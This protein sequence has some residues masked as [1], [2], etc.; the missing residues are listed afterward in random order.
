MNRTTG[1][2]EDFDP[3]V[4]GCYGR[5]PAVYAKVTSR[6]GGTQD[7]VFAYRIP[8]G[9]VCIAPANKKETVAVPT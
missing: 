2:L 3:P 5:V 8:S 6:A 7:E 4:P 9:C 1:C